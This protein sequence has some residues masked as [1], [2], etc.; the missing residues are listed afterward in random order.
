MLAS[1]MV[2]ISRFSSLSLVLV[3]SLANVRGTILTASY[4]KMIWLG[5]H[6]SWKTYTHT[7]GTDLVLCDIMH[8][9]FDFAHG[10]RSQSTDKCIVANHL[11]WFRSLLS[12]STARRCVVDW[13]GRWWWWCWTS[14]MGRS[15]RRDGFTTVAAGGWANTL[16]IGRF[17]V[18][19]GLYL[20]IGYGMAVIHSV[21]AVVV[22]CCKHALYLS[23]PRQVALIPPPTPPYILHTPFY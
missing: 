3:F 18:C 22:V 7:C 15:N 17:N 6:N 5:I 13:L 19:N 16:F 2:L 23:P 8:G 4:K 11:A 10:S 1:R 20:L 21:L 12:A 14:G 9:K